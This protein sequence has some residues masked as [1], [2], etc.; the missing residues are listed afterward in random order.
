MVEISS[1]NNPKV[2]EAMKLRDSAALRREKGLFFLEGERLVLDVFESGYT[3][4]F[5]FVTEEAFWKYDCQPFLNAAAYARLISPLAA[6]RLGDT[7][8]PQGIFAVFARKEIPLPAK[9]SRYIL[10]ENVQDPGNLGGI[11]RTAEALGAEAMLL[12]GGCDP[13]NPKA[14][15]AS[16]GSLLRLPFAQKRVAEAA[17]EAQAN[18][19]PVYATVPAADALPCTKADYSK[20][21]LLLFGNEGNGLKQTTIQKADAQITVPMHG[22]TESLGVL[23]AASILIYEMMR[24]AAA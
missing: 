16:M 17:A 21:A 3:P 7:D 14:L 9:L 10:L 24:E 18:G 5:A 1:P 8:T 6:K 22:R 15:R 20:G 4:K 19:I 23:S 13:F 12:A 2:L 11:A